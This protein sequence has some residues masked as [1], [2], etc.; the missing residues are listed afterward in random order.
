MGLCPLLISQA[1]GAL[2]NLSG[3]A[4]MLIHKKRS[5][6]NGLSGFASSRGK[7]KCTE[8]KPSGCRA[9]QAYAVAGG[10]GRIFNFI[11][12]QVA[13]RRLAVI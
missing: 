8:T 5:K 3:A 13:A 1:P 7:A 4:I 2:E 9:D 10:K 11:A 12:F 6:P